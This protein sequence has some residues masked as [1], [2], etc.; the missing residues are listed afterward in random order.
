MRN[1]QAHL[2]PPVFCAKSG[3]GFVHNDG[4]DRPPT[5]D[6]QR[7]K[8]AHTG[9]LSLYERQFDGDNEFLTPGR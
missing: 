7:E 5:G 1:R 2:R 8:F 4:T 6:T 3:T 9:R